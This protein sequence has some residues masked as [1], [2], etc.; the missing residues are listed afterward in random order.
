MT[1]T[2]T[3][4]RKELRELVGERASRRGIQVQAL[5]LVFL[6]GI[7]MPAQTPEVWLS[8]SPFALLFFLLVPSMIASTMS[9]DAFAGERERKTLETLL[10]TPLG[11]RAIV[12]GKA[13][14][15]LLVALAVAVVVVV[16]ATITVNAAGHP[17]SL[18]LPAPRVLAAALLGTLG[19]GG[20]AT[21]VALALSSRIQVARSVQQIVSLTF[22][23]P[24]ILLVMSWRRLG[25]DLVWP[26]IFI[27]LA[28]VVALGAIALI[29]AAASFRRERLLLKR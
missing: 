6:C 2:W 25:I 10:A 15:A 24:L 4:A 26:N 12:A 27:G 11:D 29:W 5:V 20:L 9:A 7:L 22:V 13:L 19:F 17:P 18:F 21:A 23:L 3:V 1:D 28:V 16:V 14:A 8:G